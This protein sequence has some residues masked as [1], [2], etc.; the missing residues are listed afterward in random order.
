MATG[1]RGQILSIAEQ[2]G[3]QC[4]PLPVMLEH[5]P[6]RPDKPD[7]PDKADAALATA[8]IYGYAR[9]NARL[10]YALKPFLQK[11]EKLPPALYLLLQL[12][13]YET[14]FLERVPEYATVHAWVD[15]A[16]KRAG[17][18]MAGLANG[19][20][21]ALVREK[22]N[23]QKRDASVCEQAE[24]VTS[25]ETL[26]LYASLPVWLTQMW[27]EFY[28]KEAAYFFCK[29]TLFAPAATYRLN[30]KAP[31][32]F[33]AQ[34]K[35]NIEENTEMAEKAGWI[36]RQGIN[37]QRLAEIATKAFTQGPVW[38]ACAGRGGKTLAML[39]N[40]VDVRLVSDTHAGRLA[41]LKANASRL[42]LPEPDIF[43]GKAEEAQEKARQMGIRHILLDAPCSG[44]GTLGR[45]PELRFRL[46][47]DHMSPL[48][49]RVADA[50]KIQAD[51]L[52]ALWQV[53]PAGGSLLYSTCAVNP[54]ENEG[55]IQKFCLTHTDCQCVEE[56]LVYST[57]LKEQGH[58][59]LYHA[60]AVKG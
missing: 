36:S 35:E 41:D 2:L 24:K 52:E 10:R 18:R 29:N 54:H 12:A 47:A 21:R 7:K 4:P 58:D 27:L 14:L 44:L 53:L 3:P 55:Q 22:D 34:H 49:Q 30:P 23:V 13:V 26:A 45:N 28:G 33:A 59:I 56:G 20:L 38:D 16:K 5:V 31:G 25:A 6:N 9:H 8:I 43:T 60:L 17:T 42:G 32:I 39:E 57:A 1:I 15:V 11:P 46:T 19:V 37:S 51:L 48:P 40:G 50:Q